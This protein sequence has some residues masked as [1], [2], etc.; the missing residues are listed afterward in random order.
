M[1]IGDAAFDSHRPYCPVAEPCRGCPWRIKWRQC[2]AEKDEGRWR[3]CSKISDSSFR[4]C[5]G[6]S[7]TAT[8]S[9][10]QTPHRSLA[11]VLCGCEGALVSF[12]CI[13][14]STNR[15]RTL[16]TLSV[17]YVVHLILPLL[18]QSLPPQIR[19]SGY[20]LCRP[21]RRPSRCH[22]NDSVSYGDRALGRIDSRSL[23]ISLYRVLEA[24]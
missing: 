6:N 4:D 18:C 22:R 16:I 24:T 2:W 5:L 9:L 13:C 7:I 23:G 14:L 8:M 10:F 1:K 12:I 21:I 17:Q 11:I 19:R 20:I 15:V 3:Q